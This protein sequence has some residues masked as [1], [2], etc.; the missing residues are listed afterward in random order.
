[1]AGKKHITK[2]GS[3]FRTSVQLRKRAPG[4]VH[5]AIGFLLQPKTVSFYVKIL[6][7]ENI[8]W[9]MVSSCTSMPFKARACLI[10][11]KSKI[12]MTSLKDKF[13]SKALKLCFDAMC[14]RH[15]S[16][17]K[18]KVISYNFDSFEKVF[19]CKCPELELSLKSSTLQ[20]RGNHIMG[21][22]PKFATYIETWKITPKLR[23]PGGLFWGQK[24]SCHVFL[25]SKKKEL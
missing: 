5:F 17:C 19:K 23:I 10:I 7:F 8:G 11:H 12:E 24:K 20:H 21:M 16:F 13:C 9:C 25:V 1:M 6:G 22:S 3:V 4:R 15:Y 18:F 2:T 14:D